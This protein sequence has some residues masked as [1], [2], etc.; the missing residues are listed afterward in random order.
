[1]TREEL[2]RRRR[3]RAV[4]QP[5]LG[6]VAVACLVAL[7]W[8][9]FQVTHDRQ[10]AQDYGTDL[11]GRVDR[12]CEQGGEAAR[13]LEATGACQR[14]TAAPELIAGPAGE[15]GDVGPVGPQGPVGPTGPTGPAGPTGPEGAPGLLGQAGPPGAAGP[16]GPAGP[17]GPEGPQGVQGPPGET[18][19]A[20]PTGPTG[21][22]GPACPSGTTL[23]PRTVPKLDDPDPDAEETW[24]VCV[25]VEPTTEGTP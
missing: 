15:R 23:E 9:M 24:H 8:M 22:A 12:A 21:P 5:I 2:E 19:P 1:M 25:Q 3:V 6:V 17:A 4:L 11:A 20:G 18:G 14:A 13:Q 7:V 10:T 16:M